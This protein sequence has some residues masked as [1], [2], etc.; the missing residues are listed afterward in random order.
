VRKIRINLIVL[1][2]GLVV[3]LGVAGNP[4]LADCVC[5]TQ[6][7]AN[8]SKSCVLTS[9][10]CPTGKTA[11]CQYNLDGACNHNI[12]QGASCMC[13]LPGQNPSASDEGRSDFC[14]Q[15]GYGPASSDPRVNTAL[16]C[17]P[18]QMD[19]FVEWLLPK[20]FGIAG[21]IAFLLMVY[22]FIMMGTSGGDP[23]KVA[24]AQETISSAITGLLLSIFALFILRLIAVDILQ[25][26]G[27]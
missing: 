21:G 5:K 8:G 7:D 2:L 17:I 22:G 4:A 20:L 26:P 12:F 18:V 19:K 23:K 15:Q 10:N 9:Q 24:G 1:L 25:I 11:T 14:V 6:T 3:F 16:G 13:L 27:F